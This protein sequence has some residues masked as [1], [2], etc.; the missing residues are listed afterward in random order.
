MH[1][2]A[3]KVESKEGQAK[4]G[5][6]PKNK[7][8]KPTEQTKADSE[9]LAEL[10]SY[11]ERPKEEKAKAKPKENNKMEEPSEHEK[12]ESEME[13][14]LILYVEGFMCDALFHGRALDGCRD[15]SGMHSMPQQCR[16]CRNKI[17]KYKTN[18]K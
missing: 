3:S 2:K 10:I 18:K 6:K 5:P 8:E 11:G 17:T 4:R 14:E 1:Q 7:K 15:F 13:A 9:V 12:A 16:K